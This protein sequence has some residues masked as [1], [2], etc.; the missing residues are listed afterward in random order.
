MVALVLN[1]ISGIVGAI[2]SIIFGFIILA[3]PKIINYALGFY[4][5]IIGILYFLAIII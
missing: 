4:L 5:I 1:G 3:F 2:I